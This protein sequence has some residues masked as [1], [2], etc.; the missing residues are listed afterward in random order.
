MCVSTLEN[1]GGELGGGAAQRIRIYPKQKLLVTSI[2]NWHDE[3]KTLSFKIS[4]SK[5]II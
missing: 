4:I 3:E 1:G 2:L 5:F